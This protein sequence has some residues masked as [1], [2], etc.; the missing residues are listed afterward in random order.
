ALPCG[1]LRFGSGF[2]LRRGL[3]LWRGLLR[4]AP[5]SEALRRS[6]GLHGSALVRARST[7]SAA[8]RLNR[9]VEIDVDVGLRAAVH[10]RQLGPTGQI[11][12][13]QSHFTVVKIIFHGAPRLR[14][15]TPA[16]RQTPRSRPP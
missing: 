6:G 8:T 4:R 12:V 15:R 16:L 10:F 13:W 2:L 3:L 11:V 14:G 7:A 9:A 1:L 5:R